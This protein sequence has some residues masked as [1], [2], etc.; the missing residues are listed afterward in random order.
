[1]ESKSKTCEQ[2]EQLFNS[3]DVDMGLLTADEFRLLPG[4]QLWEVLVWGTALT[5]LRLALPCLPDP[6][7]FDNVPPHT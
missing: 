3:A 7:E 6:I 1:M 5:A 2:H 4:E